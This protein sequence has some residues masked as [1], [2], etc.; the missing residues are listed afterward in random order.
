MRWFALAL[1]LALTFYVGK[2]SAVAPPVPEGARAEFAQISEAELREYQQL[3]DER[4]K[5][6]KANQILAKV[7]QIFIADLGLRAADATCKIGA[8][9]TATPKPPEEP[10]PAP[11]PE[12]TKPVAVETKIEPAPQ[13]TRDERRRANRTTRTSPPAESRRGGGGFTPE[14]AKGA[15]TALYQAVLW[16]ALSKSEEE[17]ATRRFADSG[18]G[19]YMDQARALVQSSEFLR[20]IEPNHT[21]QKIINHMYAVYMGRCAF[22]NELDEHMQTLQRAGPRQ[23]ITGIISRARTNNADQ[24]QSGGFPGGSCAN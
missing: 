20:E 14:K 16:R 21:P 11:N 23:V 15:M 24:I 22:P 7:M 5:V 9:E 13:L 10:A 2:K 12:P 19:L 17:L 18:W 6:G 3:K 1:I 4:E 8:T